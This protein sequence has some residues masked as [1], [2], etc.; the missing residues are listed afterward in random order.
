MDIRDIARISGYSLGTV[1]RVLNG[2]PNVSERARAS[3]LKVVEENGY[4][5]NRNARFLKMQQA[6][7]IAIFVKGSRNQ[8]FADILEHLQALLTAAGEDAVVTYIDEDGNEIEAAQH[9]KQE[10]NPKGIIF[11]GGDPA[12]FKEGFARLG[13]PAVL[14]TNTAE[15]LGF[16]NLS[17]F[18][19][20]DRLAATKVIELLFQNGHKKIGVIGGNRQEGQISALRMLGVEDAFAQHGLAFDYEHNYEPCRYAMEEGYQ[21]LARLLMRNDELTAVFA[22]GDVI[23]LGAIRAAH[24]LGKR[25]PEDLSLAGFDGLLLGQFCVPRLTSVRQDTAELAARGVRKLL[26]SIEGVSEPV[27]EFVPFR[28]QQYESVQR[29]LA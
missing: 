18:S 29:I 17:S 25:I 19:T 23:A 28:L 14:I 13:T 27:H 8:L 3:V 15:G 16:S 1:S 4:E 26:E 21:A 24:D 20:N 6:S 9:F 22:L 10:R 5:P 2:H 7:A 12:F 11:L